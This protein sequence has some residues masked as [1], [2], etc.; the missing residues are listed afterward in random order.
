M[1]IIIMFI[2]IIIIIIIITIIIIQES[3]RMMFSYFH[4]LQGVKYTS[5]YMKSILFWWVIFNKLSL[6][7]E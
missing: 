1:I 4:K 7:T 2:I 6:R 5:I 3:Y